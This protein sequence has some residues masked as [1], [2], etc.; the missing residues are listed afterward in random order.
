MGE[1]RGE[2]EYGVIPL[3]YVPLPLIPFLQGR[4]NLILCDFINLDFGSLG[5]SSRNS[6]SFKKCSG[7]SWL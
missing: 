7:T 4:G 1:G 2:G 3:A 6:Q 5:Q